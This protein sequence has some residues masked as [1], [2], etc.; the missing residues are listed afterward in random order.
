MQNKQVALIDVGSS[1]LT[2]VLGERGINK[3]FIIKARKDFHYEGFS[4]GVFF[5]EDG[6]KKLVYTVANYLK[7]SSSNKIEKLYI[8]VPGEFLKVVVKDSQISFQKKKRICDAD[9]DSLYD[10]AF[11]MSFT[12]YALINRSAIAF[13]LDDCRMLSDP[14]GENSQI[15][16]GKLSFVLCTNYF[17]EIMVES[18]KLAGILNVEFVSIPLAE[19][20]FLLQAEER[21]R[22]AMLVDVGYIST[23]FTIIQGDGI[24]FQKSFGYGG[25][26][27]TA[28][29]TDKLEI[30]F[31][32]SETLKRKVN[33][34]RQ[35]GGEYDLIESENGEFYSSQK[36]RQIINESLDLLS[37]EIS[38]AIDE[39]GYRIP[40]YVPVFITGGGIAFIRGAKE[41]IANRLGYAV[42]ILSPKVP[43][44]D[45]PT[46]SSILSVLD[47][48][49]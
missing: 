22:I 33:I 31:N 25:G 28:S 41:K 8:G 48:V 36:I 27:I 37:E 43:L 1:K 40:D 7:K 11:V 12:K 24:I 44:M 34:C 10:A 2:A 32:Q 3:T 38:N 20:M 14:I 26:Y 30:D 17:I 42:K 35:D 39:C 29:I 45:K 19:A 47:L 46:E 6:V 16:K 5:D 9:I 23:T 15:L 21:D 4:D 13:E 49:F 18:L